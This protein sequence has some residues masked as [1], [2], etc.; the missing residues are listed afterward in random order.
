VCPTDAETIRITDTYI[1]KNQPA[2][3]LRRLLVEGRDD[4]SR[5][6]RCRERDALAD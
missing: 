2:A 4:V 3:A 5:A 1:A 6:L